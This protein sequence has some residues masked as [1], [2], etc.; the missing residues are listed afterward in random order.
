MGRPPCNI[1]FCFVFRTCSPM[2]GLALLF[3]VWGMDSTG[4]A[5]VTGN[6][7]VE[8]PEH[9]TFSTAGKWFDI[10]PDARW[11]VAVIVQPNGESLLWVR[12]LGS[13]EAFPL[14]GT[15]R[16]TSPFWSPDS[17]VVGFFAQGRLTTVDVVGSERRTMCA[18]GAGF[19]ATWNHEG[20]IVFSE[21]TGL[22]QVSATGGLPSPLTQVDPAREEVVH[23][24]PQFLPD[25]RR[26]VYR[27]KSRLEKYTGIY[28]GSLERSGPAKRLVDADSNPTYSAG[29]LFFGRQGTLFVQ[30]FDLNRLRLTGAPVRI[31]TSLM[32][33]PQSGQMS[34]TVSDSGLLA[35]RSIGLQ[36]LVWLDRGG[37]EIGSVGQAG[38]YRDPAV[39]PQGD[40]VAVRRVDLQTG[41]E[42]IWIMDT[43][44]G[45]TTRL[46]TDRAQERAPVFSSDGRRLVF[47]SNRGPNGRWAL[48]EKSLDGSTV[49]WRL[50][51]DGVPTHWSG[52]GRFL[53][54]ETYRPDRRWQLSVLPMQGDTVP[55]M[56]SA[57]PFPE[58]HGQLSPEGRWMAYESDEFGV[59]NVF[60][61]SFPSDGPR[62]QISPLGGIDPRWRADGRELYYIAPDGQ[63]MS[64]AVQ[65]GSGL[66]TAP[67]RPLFHTSLSGRHTG[68][69]GRNE[70]DVTGDGERFLLIQPVARSATP[71]MVVTDWRDAVHP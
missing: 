68:V 12:A 33:N 67:P 58:T 1:S 56:F 21:K 18:C 19:G 24:W 43:V 69:T 28:V 39:S 4:T 55:M 49:A 29:R 52:D 6:R 8:P 2:I 65:F 25:G 35:Y 36:Q 9:M 30:P 60:V 48:Y 7:V 46:T 26:F 63:L 11:L 20:V 38:L 16:A 34:A 61:R 5:D 51:L 59:V 44:R 31:M 14:P 50:P 17:R 71:I 45:T 47:R 54:V 40:S 32:Q 10:S 3:A 27:I 62:W 53:V 64:V 22:W 15:E 41:M 70:Y 23:A 42:N 57:T 37:H 13:T 66:V